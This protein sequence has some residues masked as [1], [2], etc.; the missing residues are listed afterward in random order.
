MAKPAEWM[1]KYRARKKSITAKILPYNTGASSNTDSD[2]KRMFEMAGFDKVDVSSEFPTQVVGAFAVQLQNLEREYGGIKTFKNDREWSNGKKVAILTTEHSGSAY[3]WFRPE[4]LSSN[5][6]KIDLEST[7]N[8]NPSLLSDIK[9]RQERLKSEQKNG[10]KVST[11]DNILAATRYTVTHEYGHLLEQSLY[12]KAKKNGY[13]KSF[14]QFCG[15]AKRSINAIAKK[16]YGATS[17]NPSRYGGTNSKE[18]F[19]EAFTSLN[20][21]DPGPHG[22]ALNDWLIKNNYK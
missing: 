2:V 19:A 16:N 15:D 10:F 18:F 17:K 3:G 13:T 14:N 21:G 6:G 22:K 20:L 1:R 5:N 8:L 4:R 12:A 11:K 9:R 7:I